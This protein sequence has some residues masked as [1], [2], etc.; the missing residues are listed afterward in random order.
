[1]QPAIIAARFRAMAGVQARRSQGFFLLRAG[2]FG[3]K[4]RG[5]LTEV[6]HR[7]LAKNYN[8]QGD[9]LCTPIFMA[10]GPHC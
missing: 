6:R 4:H 1:M 10:F 5:L 8:S 2:R 9:A 7:R 3:R